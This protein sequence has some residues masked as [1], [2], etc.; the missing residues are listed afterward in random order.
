VKVG[1]VRPTNRRLK[2]LHDLAQKTSREARYRG[3]VVGFA[4]E[5]SLSGADLLY[6]LLQV[7]KDPLRLEQRRNVVL[8]S[9]KKPSRLRT[10]VL[11][12]LRA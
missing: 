11:G 8:L 4:F 6:E 1:A 3:A 2:A 10:I 5:R 12:C 7:P 9:P